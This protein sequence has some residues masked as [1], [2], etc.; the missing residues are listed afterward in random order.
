MGVYPQQHGPA[1]ELTLI[2]QGEGQRRA[3]L[4]TLCE[5]LVNVHGIV[6]G[7][8]CSEERSANYVSAIVTTPEMVDS[9]DWS[10][11]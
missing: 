1:R 9:I 10:T 8:A 6:G 5:S 4:F 11:L 7:K 2:S 3:T